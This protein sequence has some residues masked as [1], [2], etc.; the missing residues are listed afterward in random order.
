MNGR[1]LDGMRMD[2]V[3]IR[4]MGEADLQEVARLEGQIFSRPWSEKSFR[5]ALSS[6][7]QCYLVAVCEGILAGYCGLWC[8]FDSADLCNLAVAED[9]RKRNLGSELLCRGLAEVKNR[10]VERVLLEVRRSNA[11]AIGLYAKFGFEKLGIRPGYYSDPEED[12]I[13]MEKSL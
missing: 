1:A 2:Q 8:S 12:G 7:D 3:A 4:E 13:I 11:P 9:F 5:D 6:S 10:G